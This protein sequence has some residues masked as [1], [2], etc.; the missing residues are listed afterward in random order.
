MPDASAIRQ[1]VKDNQIWYDQHAV[2]IGRKHP[3]QWVAIIDRAVF[4]A[5]SDIVSLGRA[6]AKHPK[7][8]SAHTALTVGPRRTSSP[9]STP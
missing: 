7:R 4:V 2:E 8:D 6:I 3:E 9:T 1:Q 5:C